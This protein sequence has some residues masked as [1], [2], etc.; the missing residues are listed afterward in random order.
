[1]AS[2]GGNIGTHE[3]SR[4]RPA[5][6]SSLFSQPGVRH[7]RCNG[8]TI[9]ERVNRAM[10]LADAL[11]AQLSPLFSGAGG[12]DS[13]ISE[14]TMPLIL[15][16]LSEIEDRPLS[17]SELAQ[18][19]ALS[20]L[21]EMSLGFFRYY[22]G[23]VGDR[24]PYDVSCCGA[25]DP[26]WGVIDEIQSIEHF[27]FGWTRFYTDAL[28]YF[29]DIERA[30][31]E[32]HGLDHDALES[33]FAQFLIATE[34]MKRR[35]RRVMVSDIPKDDRFLIA[36]LACKTLEGDRP[37]ALE[38]LERAYLRLHP[39]GGRIVLKELLDELERERGEREI[40]P[41]GDIEYAIDGFL[42][43]EVE[44][45][46]D[47]RAKLQ[48]RIDDFTR[49]RGIALQNTRLYLSMIR[50]MDVYVATSMRTRQHFRGVADLCD[51]IFGSA[52]LQELN[53]RYFDPTMSAASGHEDKGLIECLMVKSSKALVYSAGDRDSWGKDAEAAMAL[54]L[55]KPVIFY[56]DE[57]TR[58]HIFDNI[59]PLSRLVSFDRGLAVGVMVVSS[60]DAVTT[61]LERIF[62]NT[63][64][65]TIREHSAPGEHLRLVEEVSGSTVRLQSADP[66]LRQAINST[67]L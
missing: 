2:R 52:A 41:R 29:G 37:L 23:P 55:G 17:H 43:M 3:C 4:E 32:L 66:I 16:H 50:E 61:L 36:E 48:T 14:K 11:R 30:F 24:H 49:A 20:N 51:E 57:A 62:T 40:P 10:D 12:I 47:L 9:G 6:K 21:P 31:Q 27:K 58:K 67:Y 53:I 22:W 65:Y 45:S 15:E 28:L 44:S 39:H 7:H 64:R 35:G 8:R 60:Q 25:Y 59:H 13:F 1:V 38:E 54:S 46:E 34:D 42:D 63:M 33:F 5:E 26:S 18:H 56:C 19:F